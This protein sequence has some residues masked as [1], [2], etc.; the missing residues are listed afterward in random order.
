[1]SISTKINPDSSGR[2]LSLN[3]SNTDQSGL[4]FTPAS[5]SDEIYGCMLLADHVYMTISDL[6]LIPNRMDV[7]PFCYM[8]NVC[9]S[10][11]TTPAAFQQVKSKLHTNK[12]G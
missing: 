10:S 7:K 1:M 9:Q 4:M 2:M 11:T 5:A 12:N 6:G 3:R 8:L